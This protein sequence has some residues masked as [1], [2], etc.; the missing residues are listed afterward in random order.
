M[1]HSSAFIRCIAGP[2]H[3]NCNKGRHWKQTKSFLKGI[4]EGTSRRMLR[5]TTVRPH[6]IVRQQG[7]QI[8]LH[9]MSANHTDP[10]NNIEKTKI[11]KYFFNYKLCEKLQC[12]TLSA[13]L[14]K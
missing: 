8:K 14:C 12:M 9:C 13:S 2:I 5:N 1:G 11:N 4:T 3:L 7:V 10:S 6:E